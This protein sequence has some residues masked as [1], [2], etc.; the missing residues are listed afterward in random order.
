MEASE[1]IDLKYILKFYVWKAGKKM[2]TLLQPQEPFFH[3]MP[4]C[5]CL[6]VSELVR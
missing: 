5:G 3:C 2:E 4:V 6:C 1:S